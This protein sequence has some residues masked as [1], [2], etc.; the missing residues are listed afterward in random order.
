[1]AL[2]NPPTLDTLRAV[3]AREAPHRPHWP[4]GFD[5]AIADPLTLAILQ[6]LALHPAAASRG[7]RR[8]PTPRQ[9]PLEALP[10]SMTSLTPLGR[11]APRSWP[12]LAR[13]EIDFKSR[14][15]GENGKD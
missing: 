14:A 3:Y 10:D 5:Q 2:R 4:Q 12:K 9:M 1:V 7:R 15:A 13:D 8:Q 11:A 6:T